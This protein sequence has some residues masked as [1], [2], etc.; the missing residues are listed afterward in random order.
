MKKSRGE[1]EEHGDAKKEKKNLCDAIKGEIQDISE[2]DQFQ[3]SME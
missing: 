2:I 1:T 3:M